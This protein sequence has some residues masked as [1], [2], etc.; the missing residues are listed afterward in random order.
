MT[1]ATKTTRAQ[2]VSETTLPALQLACFRRA[3]AVCSADTLRR[4]TAAMVQ[5][6]VLKQATS[7]EQVNHLKYD[8]ELRL[9]A[10]DELRTRAS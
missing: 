9:P 2:R 7:K 5:A 1:P 6:T 4:S 10:E 3:G 8:D